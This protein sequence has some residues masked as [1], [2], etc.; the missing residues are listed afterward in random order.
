MITK[1]E[2]LKHI[3]KPPVWVQKAIKESKRLNV[4]INGIGTDEYL[5][6]IDKIESDD[7]KNLR[8]KWLTSNRHLF[9]HLSRPVDKVF[10]AK[11]GGKIYNLTQEAKEKQL[12][13]VL[14]NVGGGKSISQWL[15]TIQA[16]KYY[17]DPAGVVF[18]EWNKAGTWPTVKSLESILC[19]KANGRELDY[20]IFNGYQKE[21]DERTYYR[22][23]DEAYDYLY[24]RS[25][26]NLTLIEN[27]TYKNPFKKVPAVIN[28]D[29]LNSSLTYAE[30]PFEP[31]ISLADHYLRTGTI[32][33]IVEFLHGYPVFWRYLTECPVCK[34]TGF[35][36][37]EDGSE[38]KTCTACG[39]AGVNLRKDIT[40]V[41]QV[42][43][44]ADA[45]DP[46]ITPDV[47]GYVTP[48]IESWQELRVE[49][50]DIRDLM[51]LTMWGSKMVK[52]KA[53]ETATAAFLDVQPVND[54]LN[55]F[56][57]AF[58]DIERKITNL[59]GVFLFGTY[60][61]ASI[62]YGRRFLVE[63]PDVI[64][65]K[66][67]KAR[68]SGAPKCSLNYLLMQFYQSEFSSDI[69]SLTVAQ[70]GMQLEPFV[71]LSDEQLKALAPAPVD[72]KRKI[73]FNEWFKMLSHSDILT[74]TVEQLNAE[75]ETYIKTVADPGTVGPQT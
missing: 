59:Y 42:K 50:N 30:S 56:A 25:G 60:E 15:R 6:K 10:T 66:Y 44:P 5:E 13:A 28:S 32:K 65:E 16:Q 36:A 4:H 71:H 39:G 63:S 57:D 58:E 69:E 18:M 40:D 38:D 45:N 21:G 64:W 17:T 74:K 52:D 12:K 35:I 1:E 62:S 24:A 43:T 75:F 9:L 14:S 7:Q 26:D 47:A 11:G 54:R 37:N 46:V 33:N 68:Q 53:N 19:Y 67:S 29:L 70:K 2:V 55:G 23:V 27:Q 3:Q 41:I 20:I 51:E 22:V 48:P 49:Q 34:G 8:K 73:Y 61:G 31:V 72:L